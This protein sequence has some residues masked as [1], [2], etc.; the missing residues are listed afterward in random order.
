V[1]YHLG[2]AASDVWEKADEAVCDLAFVNMKAILLGA[3]NKAQ[4]LDVGCFN[5]ETRQFT[6]DLDF[7]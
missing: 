7:I 1:L 6:C 2:S 5:A 3:E 4:K